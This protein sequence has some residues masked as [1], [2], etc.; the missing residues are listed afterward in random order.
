MANYIALIRKEPESDFGVDFPD[1]PGCVTAGS[2][3]EEARAMAQEALE[4]H[5]EGM[6]EDGEAIPEPS[7]LDAVMSDAANRDAVAFLVP[8]SDQKAKAVRVNITLPDFILKA[9]DQQAAESGHTRS[10]YIAWLA[11]RAQDPERSRD[12]HVV[13]IREMPSSKFVMMEEE[14]ERAKE[15]LEAMR[16]SSLRAFEEA[17]ER[18]RQL[19]KDR[20]VPSPSLEGE[21]SGKSRR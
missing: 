11:R 5:I 17:I 18:W 3:L 13:P 4:L 12:M 10:G 16:K 8:I 19:I 9:I 1:F 6:L 20:T 14:D 2:S 15:I 7:T 21:K